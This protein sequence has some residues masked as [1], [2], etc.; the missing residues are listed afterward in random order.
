MKSFQQVNLVINHDWKKTLAVVDKLLACKDS[1]TI[2]Q[3]G[4]A[5]HYNLKSIGVI[6]DHNLSKSWYRVAGPLVSRSMPWLTQMLELMTDLKPDDGAISVLVGDVGSHIDLPCVPSALNYIF[7]S[8]DSTAYTWIEDAGKIETYP[9]AVDTA[10]IL[11]T[12]ILH[13]VKSNGKRYALSIHF[14]VDYDGVVDWFSTRKN[15][16]FGNS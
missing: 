1:G 5:T 6:S 13:G 15:L 7:Y 3:L 2:D 8:D 11:N 16:V 4:N 12:Q 10:W 14:G 9:S